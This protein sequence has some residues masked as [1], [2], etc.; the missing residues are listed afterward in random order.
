LEQNYPNPF[1]PSTNIRFTIPEK[2]HVTLKVF[3]VLG[4]EITTLVN[5][6]KEAGTYNIKFNAQNLPSGVY[7]YT[8][9]AGKYTATKKMMLVK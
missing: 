7:L 5:E 8:L 2:E 3:D 1:N 9:A 4:R 6:V